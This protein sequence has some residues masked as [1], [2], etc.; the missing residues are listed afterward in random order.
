MM[1]MRIGAQ[2]F[3]GMRSVTLCFALPDG[4]VDCTPFLAVLA[5]LAGL[6]YEASKDPLSPVVDQLPR[7]LRPNA[8]TVKAAQDAQ[9]SSADKA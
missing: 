6:W 1:R 3:T 9:A 4:C 2:G 8:A 7:G 5:M